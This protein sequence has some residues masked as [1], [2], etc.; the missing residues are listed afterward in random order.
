MAF[1]PPENSGGFCVGKGG[2]FVS[3]KRLSSGDRHHRF[4]FK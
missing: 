4:G 1:R 2:G 3:F